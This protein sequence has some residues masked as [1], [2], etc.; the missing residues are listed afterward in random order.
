MDY[1][2]EGVQAGPL[3]CKVLEPVSQTVDIFLS[4]YN[5]RGLGWNNK[6]SKR[7]QLAGLLREHEYLVIQESKKPKNSGKRPVRFPAKHSEKHGNDDLGVYLP[8]SAQLVAERK[9]SERSES[10]DGRCY[11]V[12]VFDRRAQAYISIFNLHLEPDPSKR[13]AGAKQTW[14]FMQNDLQRAQR[15]RD[16]TFILGDLN[17]VGQPEDNSKMRAKPHFITILK[18][19]GFEEI[20]QPPGTSLDE[21]FTYQKAVGKGNENGPPYRSRLDQVWFYPHEAI[22]GTS[23]EFTSPMNSDHRK[24]N[25]VVKARKG[26]RHCSLPPMEWHHRFLCGRHPADRGDGHFEG[27]WREAAILAIFGEF[28]PEGVRRM[29]KDSNFVAPIS[30]FPKDDLPQDLKVLTGC[31]AVA[32][33]LPDEYWKRPEELL[34]VMAKAAKGRLIRKP[35]MPPKARVC[36]LRER[37]D[38]A[39]SARGTINRR[40]AR[41][42]RHSGKLRIYH[43]NRKVLNAVKQEVV[44]WRKMTCIQISKELRRVVGSLRAERVRLLISNWYER[45]DSS[46]EDGTAEFYRAIKRSS[47]PLDTGAFYDDTGRLEM[48]PATVKKYFA[49]NTRDQVTAPVTHGIPAPA[50]AQHPE[51]AAGLANPPELWEIEELEKRSNNSSPGI[52]GFTYRGLFGILGTTGVWRTLTF[53]WG[54]FPGEW[55]IILVRL[56]NKTDLLR[57][58]AGKVRPI[59]LSPTILKTATGVIQLR[60]YRWAADFCVFPATAH[61]FVP[62]GRLCAGIQARRA[63]AEF[64]R[65]HNRELYEIQ[66]DASAAFDSPHPDAICDALRK[67]GI[68]EEAV[69]LIMSLIT[70][71]WKRVITAYGLCDPFLSTRG[72]PQGDRL[73]P[74]LWALVTAPF[75]EHAMLSLR[76]TL[77]MPDN[78]GDEPGFKDINLLTF[79]DD[80]NYLTDCVDG[81]DETKENFDVNMTGTG[82]KVNVSKWVILAH[83][84][85][86]TNYAELERRGIVLTKGRVRHL[87][88]WID[89]DDVRGAFRQALET[90]KK[91]AGALK[92]RALGANQAVTA[93]NA[94]LL[95]KLLYQLKNSPISGQDADALAKALLG[96]VRKSSAVASTL[97]RKG[98]TSNVMGVRD[99]RLELAG[100]RIDLYLQQLSATVPESNKYREHMDSF[101]IPET[102]IE[103]SLFNHYTKKC[104]FNPLHFPLAGSIL[105]P[106]GSML[107]G[108]CDDLVYLGRHIP[109]PTKQPA[110]E[111][112]VVALGG[113]LGENGWRI[114]GP[115]NSDYAAI[116]DQS[117]LKIGNLEVEMRR[118][119]LSANLFHEF[120]GECYALIPQPTRPTVGSYVVQG[121]ESSDRRWYGDIYRV[122]QVNGDDLEVHYLEPNVDFSHWEPADE[123]FVFETGRGWPN[124]DLGPTGTMALSDVLPIAMVSH[125]KRFYPALP[126]NHLLR[127]Y[128]PG[129]LSAFWRLDLLDVTSSETWSQVSDGGELENKR[130]ATDG[131]KLGGRLGF[132]IV[133]NS[134]DTRCIETR[135]DGCVADWATS[136]EAE[137]IALLSALELGVEKCV[138]ETDSQ[139]MVN[140]ANGG[141][142]KNFMPTLLRKIRRLV[143]AKD[144]TVRHVKAHK[145]PADVRTSVGNCQA[146]R[147]AKIGAI[148]AFLRPDFK[149]HAV[150]EDAMGNQWPHTTRKLVEV[151]RA[152]PFKQDRNMVTKLSKFHRRHRRARRKTEVL[153]LLAAQKSVFPQERCGCGWDLTRVVDCDVQ[154]LHP[155]VCPKAKWW[156]ENEPPEKHVQGLDL[157]WV[158]FASK[159]PTGFWMLDGMKPWGGLSQHSEWREL[160]RGSKE[161]K[162]LRT[163]FVHTPGVNCI[164]HEFFP[165]QPDDKEATSEVAEWLRLTGTDLDEVWEAASAP[166]DT[167]VFRADRAKQLEDN[168]RVSATRTESG[169]HG[170]LIPKTTDLIRGIVLENGILRFQRAPADL[171]IQD[172]MGKALRP[173]WAFSANP[174]RE[175]KKAAFL[176]LAREYGVSVIWGDADQNLLPR[177]GDHADREDMMKR[178]T[179]AAVSLSLAEDKRKRRQDDVTETTASAADTPSPQTNQNTV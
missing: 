176:T 145:R 80:C 19:N 153:Q 32:S 47:M 171:Y 25:V 121:F 151:L 40:L 30:K 175:A 69:D 105:L 138:V 148:Q 134:G 48:D 21:S 77:M 104:G 179:H 60:I 111:D 99:L 159:W 150:L 51:W 8:S 122:D 46:Y 164:K 55:K 92:L 67:M 119:V 98:M 74:L 158:K 27:Q 64:A 9:P 102:R 33:A 18:D 37:I 68:G 39:A 149:E 38:R 43:C 88:V 50:T 133:G 70:G 14:K 140:V 78:E 16:L 20:R 86:A 84:P 89:P 12:R 96:V 173:L 95:P 110:I 160:T 72:T 57:P 156:W 152:K 35:M 174:D 177:V 126:H 71:L 130:M 139:Y 76:R 45:M 15:R 53:C 26:S 120:N 54:K 94:I 113:S 17:E 131:S 107:R 169:T 52:D 82:V 161:T 63:A 155:V 100:S 34:N 118:T 1:G 117:G 24:V 142:I 168:W 83:A 81:I 44:G 75:Q 79:A 91:A 87:G 108:V 61:G 85:Q 115:R 106:S 101:A 2:N 170:I 93:C 56:L 103:K 23:I 73:S 11:Y 5:V 124:G 167:W 7:I 3:E 4:T 116:L 128:A 154:E 144:A 146:D 147:M 132:S 163:T 157:W 42:G 136:Q 137:A 65:E 62:F 58:P 141:V 143:K 22:A 28:A 6:D 90:L 178:Y 109:R 123:D 129:Y 135:F 10:G 112:A 59:A 166:G 165:R 114:I 41:V 97:S 13:A 125:E 172:E 36:Q 127:A 29:R 162:D 49:S 31:G 66:G